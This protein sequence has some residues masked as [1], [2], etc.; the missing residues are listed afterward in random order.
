MG[1]D[2]SLI[3][4]RLDSILKAEP[5]RSLSSIAVELGISRHTAD[6][7]LRAVGVSFRDLRLARTKE[8]LE[9]LATAKRPL[10]QKELAALLGFGSQ[11]RL[12]AWRRRLEEESAIGAPVATEVTILRHNSAQKKP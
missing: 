12:L 4:E 3:V 9:R 1:Y 6:R 2:R 7:A 11:R 8:A 5:G 10:L